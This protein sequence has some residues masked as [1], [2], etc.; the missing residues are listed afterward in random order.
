LQEAFFA[1]SS[2]DFVAA[3][4]LFSF[5]RL[6]RIPMVGHSGLASLVEWWVK[7]VRDETRGGWVVGLG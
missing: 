7:A 3:I 2:S 6:G 5:N 1:L 4:S